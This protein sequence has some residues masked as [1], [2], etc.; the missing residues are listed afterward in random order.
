MARLLRSGAPTKSCVAMVH[1]SPRGLIRTPAE[2]DPFITDGRDLV[3]VACGCFVFGE[4][5]FGYSASMAEHGRSAT[6]TM[7]PVAADHVGLLPGEVVN[8]RL[9]FRHGVG[10][11]RFVQVHRIVPWGLPGSAEVRQRSQSGRALSNAP[12]LGVEAPGP[13]TSYQDRFHAE[14]GQ[15]CFARLLRYCL[16]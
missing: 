2:Q 7:R 15:P 8:C 1:G 10:M 3:G 14:G 4:R 12:Q 9:Q 16:S 5:T 11:R 6:G 13:L